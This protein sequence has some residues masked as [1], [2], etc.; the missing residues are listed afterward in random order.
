MTTEKK[1]LSRDSYSLLIKGSSGVGKTSLALT[2]LGATSFDQNFLYISTNSSPLQILKGRP[3]LANRVPEVEESR[4]NVTLTT[5]RGA[6]VDSRLDEQS[7]VYERV[8]NELMDERSPLIV[9]DSWDSILDPNDADSILT[10]VKVLQIWRE[11][12]HAKLIF[13]C[14][15]SANKNFEFLLDGVVGLNQ[16]FISGRRVREIQ[17]SKLQGIEISRP[18]YFFTLSGGIFRSF[19]P[20]KA[21]DFVRPPTASEFKITKGQRDAF[22]IPTGFP[23]LDR[24]LSGGLPTKSVATIEIDPSVDFRIALSFLRKMMLIHTN[25]GGPTILQLSNEIAGDYAKSAKSFV[26]GLDRKLLRIFLPNTN[27]ETNNSKVN[28]NEESERRR[29]L[30]K[31]EV[32]YMKKE[33]YGK[34]LLAIVQSDAISMSESEWRRNYASLMELARQEIDVLVLITRRHKISSKKSYGSTTEFE[35]VSINGT[36]FLTCNSPWSQFYALTAEGIDNRKEVALAEM[37]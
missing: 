6:F 14:E 35:I 34:S 7:A 10:N 25:N 31:Q 11:R 26:A 24:L 27:S 3:W 20:Y 33:F 16:Y 29:E 4:Q 30:F 8:T 2:I 9:I 17:F 1:L 18:S 22:H 23:Q 5:A 28:P 21:E 37:I 32:L 36:L 13:T 15:E 19:E 12:A